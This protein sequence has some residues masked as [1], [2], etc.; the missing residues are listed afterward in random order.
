MSLCFVFRRPTHQQLTRSSMAH[1]CAC[2][3]FIPSS[4]KR[5]DAHSLDPKLNARAKLTLPAQAWI[6]L[7]FPK[8]FLSLQSSGPLS[9]FSSAKVQGQ[10]AIAV[11]D[12]VHYA[13]LAEC[14]FCSG[15][16]LRLARVKECEQRERKVLMDRRSSKCLLSTPCHVAKL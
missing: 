9:A 13:N 10:R 5:S 7:D 1:A 11:S 8:P 4:Q 6:D 15:P 2:P 3:I 16:D 12:E 14:I